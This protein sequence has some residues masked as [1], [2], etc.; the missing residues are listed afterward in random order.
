M[1]PLHIALQGMGQLLASKSLSILI[2]HQVL[3]EPDRMRPSEPTAA[4][5]DWQMQL[6]SKYY[7]PIS[8]TTALAALDN[9]TLPVN[10]ICVTF[11]DGYLNNLE[12]AE[13]ILAKYQIP[14][15]VYVATHFAGGTNM[16]NDRILDLIGDEQRTLFNLSALNMEQQAV[17]STQERIVLAHKLIAQVKYLHFQKRQAVVDQ[18]YQDNQA[19]EYPSRMMNPAQV[20]A[21]ADKGVDIGAHTTDHP[22]LRTLPAEQQFQQIL[23]SKQQLAQWADKSIAHFAYPNG[24]L[25]DDYSEETV[26]QVQNAGFA[27]AVSTHWG[28]NNKVAD[29]LQLKRFTPWDSNPLKFHLRLTMNQLGMV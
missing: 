18:L 17:N 15:T 5:F 9:N 23:E 19:T 16:F 21:L 25:H 1:Q 20:R 27:S 11:D 12:V 24:K 2:Y 3:A 22:I 4:M 13:P 14:A 29:R 26:T 8:L 6:I 28:V 10:A 7:K